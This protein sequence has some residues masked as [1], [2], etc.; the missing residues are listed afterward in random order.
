VTDEEI[1][2]WKDQIDR[3]SRVEMAK[4][5]RFAP[6]GHPIFNTRLPLYEYFKARYDNVGGMNTAISK[7]IGWETAHGN[8]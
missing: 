8:V 1:Q 4:L 2:E 7:Q 3:M 5:W 6:A